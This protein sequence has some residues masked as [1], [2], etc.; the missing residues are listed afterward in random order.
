M[1]ELSVMSGI[2]DVVSNSAR[3]NG[4]EKVKKVRLIVG[5]M[6]NALPDALQMGFE[7]LKETGPFTEDAVLEIEFI[8]TT[9]KC[10]D[11]EYEYHPEEGYIFT[12]P[13]CKSIR[14]EV[15]DGEQLYVDYYEGDESHD[16]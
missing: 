5:Q 10:L 6:S 14:T 2:I 15:I 4:I 12:C 11:C 1:H 7:M 8:K 16:S 9:V 13:T 3:E